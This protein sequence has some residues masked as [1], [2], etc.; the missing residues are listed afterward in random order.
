MY[1]N[2]LQKQQHHNIHR[3]QSILTSLELIHMAAAVVKFHG[4]TM[5]QI[6]AKFDQYSL[7]IQ[8]LYDLNKRFRFI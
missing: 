1:M 2:L 3:V 7:V 8:Y 4:P 5:H 6:T